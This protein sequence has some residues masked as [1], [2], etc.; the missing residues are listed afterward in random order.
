MMI[1]SM[2]PMPHPSD[3]PAYYD[4]SSLRRTAPSQRRS[5]PLS[6]TTRTHAIL[7]STAGEGLR[8]SVLMRNAL[9]RSVAARHAA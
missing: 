3:A 7:D 1:S 2:S 6:T 9:A 4:G 5:P 8:R